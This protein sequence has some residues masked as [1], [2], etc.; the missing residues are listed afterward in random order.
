MHIHDIYFRLRTKS[1]LISVDIT[2]GYMSIEAHVSQSSLHMV[3]GSNHIHE[4]ISPRS[5]PASFY[6]ILE[7]I[8]LI[9]LF[10]ETIMCE[11][12]NVL[13]YFSKFWG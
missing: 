4:S 6:A 10:S 8:S 7:L 2:D 3:Y 12:Y 11:I 1:I 9:H 13:T 5:L